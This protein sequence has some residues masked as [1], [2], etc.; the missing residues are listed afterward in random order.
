MSSPS[1]SVLIALSAWQSRFVSDWK[2]FEDSSSGAASMSVGMN[3]MSTSGL[4]ASSLKFKVVG[5]MINN[6]IFLV[7]QISPQLC[8]NIHNV[9]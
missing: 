5:R 3:W 2:F 8:K 7:I 6:I 1:F 9:W 4:S